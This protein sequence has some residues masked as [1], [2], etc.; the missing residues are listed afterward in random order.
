[1]GILLC[2]HKY[3]SCIHVERLRRI[4]GPSVAAELTANM[5]TGVTDVTLRGICLQCQSKCLMSRR[6]CQKECLS[7]RSS[8]VKS[9]TLSSEMPPIL[10]FSIKSF[11]NDLRKHH[12]RKVPF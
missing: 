9:P 6:K 5:G 10:S 11:L 3:T 7:V 1:M 8:K 4:V 12:Y 2:I